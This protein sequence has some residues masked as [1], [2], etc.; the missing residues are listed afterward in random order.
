MY[1]EEESSLSCFLEHYEPEAFFSSV[2]RLGLPHSTH[3]RKPKPPHL[4]KRVGVKAHLT[5]FY[6]SMVRKNACCSEVYAA[7]RNLHKSSIN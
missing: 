6:L 3:S 2:Q 5:G 7:L 1:N 4:P